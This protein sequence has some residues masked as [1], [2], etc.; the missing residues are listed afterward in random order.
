MK[1]MKGVWRL[2]SILFLTMI[3]SFSL[4]QAGESSHRTQAH[5]V[6]QPSFERAIAVTLSHEGGFVDHPSDPGG[7]TK[8]GI[9]LR[10]LQDLGVD[11]DRDGDVDADDIRDLTID[12]AKMLYFQRFWSRYNYGSFPSH[13]VAAK[14]FDLSVNMG[15]RQAHKLLQRAM[16][17]C[18]AHLEDDGILGPITRS[19]LSRVDENC[20]LSALRSEAAG[21]YRY[22]RRPEFEKGW[23]RR[24][25]S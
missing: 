2:P 7:A 5:P 1:T 14:V 25:Y 22:L 15:P 17:A 4:C 21:F 13:E 6:S 23:L 8:Y 19:K 9:S 20:L 10:F 3:S 12:Q 16:R 24:A 18:G 11:I